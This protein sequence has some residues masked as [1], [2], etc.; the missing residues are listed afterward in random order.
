MKL[1]TMHVAGFTCLGLGGLLCP[2]ITVAQDSAR[3]EVPSSPTAATQ[4]PLAPAAD[5]YCGDA[6]SEALHNTSP[7]MPC[8]ADIRSTDRWRASTLTAGELMQAPADNLQQSAEFNR[9]AITGGLIQGDA[10]APGADTTAYGGVVAAAITAGRRRW[11]FS[12]DDI[13]S[14]GDFRQ[15]GSDAAVGLNL[16]TLRLKTELTPRVLLQVR[17]TNTFGTDAYRLFAPLDYHA[18]GDTE[19][20]VSATAAYG[21]HAG[22]VIAEGEDASVR[23]ASS[24]RTSWD[25]SAGHSLQN[26]SDFGTTVQTLRGRAEVLHAVD[27]LTAVGAFATVATQTS[28]HQAAN[29]PAC[30]LAGG[31]LAMESQTARVTLDL[32]GG[33]ASATDGC[34]HSLQPFGNGA[35]TVRTGSKSAMYLTLDRGLSGG[36]LLTSPLLSS[37]GVGFR[38]GFATGAGFDISAGG[39][40]GTNAITHNDSTAVFAD[41]GIHYYLGRHLMQQTSVRRFQNSAVDRANSGPG[42]QTALTFSLWITRGNSA[43]ASD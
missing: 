29:L 38:H 20:P 6:V 40:L 14:G 5:V 26:Y 37:A 28:A 18:V 2:G 4:V 11:Q 10:L 21:L 32:A 33:V 34:G 42:G 39:L 43:K 41:A 23:Y 31:G 17:A 25:F 19:A 30:T 9:S 35:L 27:A 24:R 15:K 12:A 3:L 36:V 8:W 22:R 1:L 7:E 13:G 16:V